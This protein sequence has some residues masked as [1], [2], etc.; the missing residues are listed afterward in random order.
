MLSE[1]HKILLLATMTNLC[2]PSVK[3]VIACL[4]WNK[5]Q[6]ECSQEFE[7]LYERKYGKKSD[8]KVIGIISSKLS[9]QVVGMRACRLLRLPFAEKV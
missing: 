4:N 5:A 8:S 9:K 7:K 1:I 6:L 2:L 3:L